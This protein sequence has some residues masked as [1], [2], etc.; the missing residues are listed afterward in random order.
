MNSC[1]SSVVYLYLGKYI[2]N[3]M[4]DFGLDRFLKFEITQKNRD[5]KLVNIN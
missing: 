2:Q 5:N 4:P 1:K 3:R